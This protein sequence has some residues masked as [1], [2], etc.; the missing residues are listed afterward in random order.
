M[1]Y[2]SNF[3]LFFLGFSLMAPGAVLAWNLQGSCVGAPAEVNIGEFVTWTANQTSTAKSGD[4]TFYTWEWSGTD[5]L[6]GTTQNISKSYAIAGIKSATV[7]ITLVISPTKKE[8]ITKN[9]G[10]KVNETPKATLKVVKEVINI[11]GGNKTA[12]DFTIHIKQNGADISDSPAAG[13]ASGQLY[14][15]TPGSFIISE[16]NIPSDY[17]LQSIGGDCSLNGAVSIAAGESKTCVVTNIHKTVPPSPLDGVCSVSP[18][19][20]KVG[21]TVTWSATAT[22]GNGAHTYSWSGTDGLSGE[23]SSVAKSYNSTGV[24]TGT[25][26][27]FS[28][29]ETITKTCEM[30]V[31]ENPSPPPPPSDWTAIC[32]A[33]SSSV[34]AGSSVTWKA[35]ITGAAGPFTYLWS[36]TDGLSGNLENLSFVYGNAGTKSASVTVSDGVK[37][38]TTNACTVNIMPPPGCTSGCG[39]GG[40]NPP[41]VVLYQKA[42]KLPLAFVYLSQVPYTGFGDVFKVAAFLLGIALWSVVVV[43]LWKSGIFSGACDKI[44]SFFP[45]G[46]A[47]EK[48]FPMHAHDENIMPSDA[49]D[50]SAFAAYNAYGEET[51]GLSSGASLSPEDLPIEEGDSADAKTASDV[52]LVLDGGRRQKTLISEDAAKIIAA[53]ANRRKVSVKEFIGV[54]IKTAEA[55]YI[56]EDGW[57]LLNR[58]KAAVLIG[59]LKEGESSAGFISEV[60]KESHLA[61]SASRAGEDGT[62]KK[63]EMSPLSSI[64]KP[65]VASFLKTIGEG[66][67]KKISAVI[68]NISLGGANA[69]DFI[70]KTIY[71]IDRAYRARFDGSP[72][73]AEVRSVTASWNNESIEDIIS[74]LLGV[75]DQ[76]YRDSTVGVKLAALRLSELKRGSQFRS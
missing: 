60:E 66:D 57:I 16:S 36:G 37:T 67:F 52:G 2:P 76:N 31:T 1:K 69:D 6:S 25:I 5:G 7:K 10:V 14:E 71:E 68:K 40:F 15:V 41:E 47:S 3:W 54:L 53:E 21:E 29:P 49:L 62:L 58:E 39:G 55:K 59:S 56:R 18:A 28:K 30:S 63:G 45:R 12:A 48:E 70:R 11:D 34:P 20:V 73:D 72:V 32:Q 50:A 22:G 24:K 65:S 74:I 44:K 38:V 26:T 27:I 46:E 51:I 64:L 43:Y 35:I 9:C 75:L 33:G 17:E 23:T 4:G 19:S 42:E 61:T 8:S 13:S